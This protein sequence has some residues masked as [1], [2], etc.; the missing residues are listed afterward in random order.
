MREKRKVRKRSAKNNK[1]ILEW[2]A[3]KDKNRRI[4]FRI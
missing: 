2:K 4:R 1:L 3:R